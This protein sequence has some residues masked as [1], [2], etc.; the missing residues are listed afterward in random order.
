M[1]TSVPYLQLVPRSDAGSELGTPRMNIRAD[2]QITGMFRGSPAQIYA[3]LLQHL[4]G[5]PVDAIRADAPMP[6]SWSAA[7]SQFPS[8]ITVTS[9]RSGEGDIV[10]YCL[11]SQ[12]GVNET[13]VVFVPSAEPRN[14]WRRSRREEVVQQRCQALASQATIMIMRF[15]YAQTVRSSEGPLDQR[16]ESPLAR[17]LGTQVEWSAGDRWYTRADRLSARSGY[18]RLVGAPLAPSVEMMVNAAVEQASTILGG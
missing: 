16:S 6:A 10:L 13:S 12:A 18:L 3:T 5:T 9:P 15:S 17:V 1:P 11:I 8:L 2:Q 4:P 14:V 7:G